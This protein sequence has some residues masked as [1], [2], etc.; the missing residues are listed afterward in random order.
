MDELIL[1][2]DD[3]MR[4]K[5]D[6]ISLSVLF[7]IF[8]V[9][10]WF[11]TRT[12]ETTTFFVT[13]GLLVLALG[14]TYFKSAKNG[15]ATLH[16]KGDRLVIKFADGRKYNISDVDRSYFSLVQT[17]KQKALDVG[18]L[19][20]QSTNFKVQYIKQ[21]SLLQKYLETHFEKQ[22]PKGIYYL[23]DEDEEE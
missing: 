4:K 8:T 22:E 10:L 7:A 11:F 1:S 9:V 19:S 6:L 17:E 16:F 15:G 2:T 3:K 18:T 23:D 20:V 14:F 12:A 13:E 5:G 21:F